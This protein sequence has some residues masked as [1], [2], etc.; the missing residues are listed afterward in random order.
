MKKLLTVCLLAILYVT[1]AFAQ[2]SVTVTVKDDVGPVPGASVLIKGTTTGEMTDIDGIAKLTAKDTDV[3][4]VS[5]IGYR[6]VEVTVGTKSKIDVTL[7]VDSEQLEETVVVGYGTQKKASLTSA[8]TNVKAEDITSTKQSSLV[9]SLQGKIPG[10]QIRQQSGKPGSFDSDLSLRGFG[11]PLIIIDGVARTELARDAVYGA[12]YTSGAAALAQLNPEDIESITVLKD[13]SAAIYGLGADNGV[14][15]V[16][17][18]KGQIGKPSVNYSNNFSFGVPTAFPEAVDIVTYMRKEN[19]MRVNSRMAPQYTEE[20]IQHYVNG[21]PGYVDT[22]WYDVIMKDYTFN[23]THNVSLRGG[24]QQTQYYLS[25]NFTEDNS[26]FE[27]DNMNN[28]RYNFTGNVTSKI[29]PELTAM[30][31]TTLMSSKN[32]GAPMNTNMNIFYYAALGDRTIA[33]TVNGNPD[34]YSAL[35]T[36]ENRNPYGLL[37]RDAAGYSDNYVTSLRNNLEVRYE[38]TW[39]KGLSIS[40]NGAYDYSGYRTNT[41]QLAFPLYDYWTDKFVINNGDTPQYSEEWSAN[42]R[43]YG[44]VQA[45]YNK[46]IGAHNIGATLAA[47]L[48][49]N[50]SNNI[51]GSRQYG[52]FYTHDVLNQAD[53]STQT[54]SGSRNMNAQAGYIARVS[55]DYMGKYLVDFTGRYDGTYYYAPGYRWGFFPAYSVGYRISEEKWFKSAMPWFN[56]LKFRWSDGKTGRAQGS[57]YAWQLGYTQSGSYV[58]NDG[59]LTNGY[60]SHAVAETLLSWTDVRS[61]DFGVD[62]EMWRG[63]FGGSIDWFWRETSGIAATASTTVPDFYGLSLPQQNLNKSE[64]VGIDLQISHQ[65]NIGEFWYRV[66]ATGTFA[67]SRTTYREADKTAIYS[68]AMS[69]Y[70]GNST[71]RWGNARGAQTFH[72]A[73]GSQ[74][75]NI[76][77]ASAHNVLYDPSKGMMDIL[78]GMYK[79]EDRNGDGVLT[80]SDYYYTWS[81]SN[82]PLQFGLILSGRYKGFDFNMSF[83]GATLVNKEISLSGAFGYGFFQTFYENYMDHYTLADGYTDPFDPNSK[84]V[85]GYFPAIAKATSAYDGK[86]SWGATGSNYPYRVNQPYNFVDGTYFRLKS[87]ELGYTLPAKWTN[88]IKVKSLRVYVSGTNLFTI[89]NK[90]LKPYD[91]ERNE[92]AWLGAGGYPLMRTYSFGLNLNF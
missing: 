60:V 15:L 92:N 31:Q 73:D 69:Y 4:V 53:Q 19:E 14:I 12:T 5:F 25:G 61:M 85:G 32:E 6:T 65:N 45:N 1:S 68:S 81:E 52:D 35:P 72:W 11:Q 56:N 8:I 10:L 26:L 7:E 78:P 67:R 29:T 76:N 48:T 23:M 62:W 28:R 33:P 79:I 22:D 71:G 50:I 39:L 64:N 59:S 20:L 89:C 90:L 44:R 24:N 46:R 40:A 9:S 51:S 87:A 57:P 49:K 54:N 2:S 91:P 16:T 21:D 66:A 38:P 43:L 18:K 74:F 82:P 83:A 88:A 63:K 70:T 47:E 36:A 75:T 84:W 13:A 30:F 17:T 42:Q 27:S 37:D 34:H 41:L 77:E 3:L 58:F 55:Y 86:T 80:G